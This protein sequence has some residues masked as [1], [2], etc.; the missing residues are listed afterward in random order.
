MG[1]PEPEVSETRIEALEKALAERDSLLAKAKETLK[2]EKSLRRQAE[3]RQPVAG[4]PPTAEWLTSAP[5]GV[6]QV[7]DDRIIGC[8]SR[9]AELLGWSV[10]GHQEV[11]ELLVAL[12]LSMEP[13]AGAPVI[14]PVGEGAG[15][16]HLRVWRTPGPNALWMWWIEDFSRERDIEVDR[17]RAKQSL[18]NSV[19]LFQQRIAEREEAESR[20]SEAISA[21]QIV[22]DNAFVGITEIRDGRIIRVNP[23]MEQMFGY[24]PGELIGA[25]SRVC[26]FNDESYEDVGK[27]GNAILAKGR[28]CRMDLP[29]RRKN[30]ALMW[31]TIV[32]KA[33][34]PNDLSRGTVWVMEDITERKQSL[35]ELEQAMI[36]AEAMNEIMQ[37][38][39]NERKQIEERLKRL[40]T[41]NQIIL[42]RS[43]L[44]IATV[45]DRRM[46]Q[47]NQRLSEMLGW[48]MDE[49]IDMPTARLFDPE[50]FE[51]FSAVAYP[52]LAGG[53]TYTEDVTMLRRDGSRFL[54]RV[55]GQALDP[56]RPMAGS[57]WM[58]EDVT[59]SRMLEV[60][61]KQTQGEREAI[62][63]SLQVGVLLAKER[64]VVWANERFFNILGYDSDELINQ[65]TRVYFASDDEYQMID[66]EGYPTINQGKAYFTKLTLT[67]RDG[68]IVTCRVT[69][70]AVN[71]A[72]L[73]A[74]YIWTFDDISE[75]MRAEEKTRKALENLQEAQAQ[76]VE[77]EKMAALGGLVAGVAHEVNTPL[78]VGITAASLLAKKTREFGED[79]REGRMKKKSDLEKYVDVAEQSSEIILANLR[80]AVDL[81]QS[82][83]RVAVDQSSEERR[84]FNVYSYTN[85][86]LLSL[87]PKFARTRIRT[88]LTGD[89]GVEIDSFPGAFSQIVSNLVMNSLMHGFDP[90]DVGVISIRV[91]TVDNMAVIVYADDGKGIP[92]DIIGK[93]YDPF[94]TTKRGQGGSGLG[95]HIIYNIITQSLKGS[96]Q[97]D[98]TVGVGTTFTI[99]LPMHV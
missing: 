18:A 94:F 54:C 8:S 1:S 65:P 75:L 39:I 17:D 11:A 3:K 68:S 98:S 10:E 92:S 36:T 86:V 62:L 16:R 69:G 20:Y 88:E 63:K 12:N 37:A 81:I 21:L 23:R 15:R 44:G 73:S 13:P 33:I 28:S 25:Q 84:T 43:P 26:H 57:V 46:A 61:L 83:K 22:F 19:A 64:M 50:D 5:F 48:P 53:S 67:R 14:V 60:R 7:S 40:I 4:T 74:G 41:E 29:M 34:D 93:I 85:D 30:G 56:T 70:N 49:L 47:A 72:D 99:K 87:K 35:E 55:I 97:C 58:Y 24:D 66:Q 78:G 77:S 2:L 96:I 89:E 42:N 6:I 91:G 27:V 80:R 32:G 52:S 82:F 45:R 59:E 31:C 38:E 79:Y 90:D 76:L 71:V 9:A 51:R 95:L